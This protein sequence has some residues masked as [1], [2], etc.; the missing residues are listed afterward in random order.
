[1]HHLVM[2]E[3][4]VAFLTTLLCVVE[5]FE[6]RKFALLVSNLC[7]GPVDIPTV[8]NFAVQFV[9]VIK[10]LQFV[11]HKQNCVGTAQ[12]SR[13]F[14]LFDISSHN[15][16]LFGNVGEDVDC[17]KLAQKCAHF[18]ERIH[19]VTN[20]SGQNEQCRYTCVGHCAIVQ[21]LRTDVNHA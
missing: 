18:E 16:R 2:V 7:I 12:A 15:K 5:F 11:T 1:M 14:H 9:F 20:A 13:F 4:F 6:Q 8:H 10:C 3:T 17:I 19:F 21:N